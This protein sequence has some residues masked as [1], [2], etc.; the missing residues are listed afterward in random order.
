[1]T[2]VARQHIVAAAVAAAITSA[3]T[4]ADQ[5]F[6]IAPSPG[7][8]AQAI[9]SPV[10]NSLT[11][12]G[13]DYFLYFVPPADEAEQPF[14]GNGSA[15]VDAAYAS[16]DVAN[17]SSADAGLGYLR[18]SASSD[19]P[20]GAFFP[21]A[22]ANACWSETF[23]VTAPGLAG[24][25]GILQFTL[26]ASGA[27]AATGFA[28]STSVTVTGY[29]NGSQLMNNQWFSPGGS[30]PIGTDRQY[31][32][33]GVATYGIPPTD[34]KTVND[35][36]TFAVPFV[37]GTPFDLDICA[38]ALAGLRSV[39][40]VPGN[41]TAD[42]DFSAGITWGGIQAVLVNG[43]PIKGYSVAG[44]S[45]I[46]WSDPISGPAA[47]DLNGDGSVNA[48]DLALLL[49]AWGTPAGDLDGDG[50][51]GASDLAI[52]LAAWG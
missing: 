49:S 23:V 20:N 16:G 21:L 39:S 2:I 5:S 36:V 28:G 52:L 45:G 11:W 32:H 17:A 27:L 24:Q 25:P 14:A 15:G 10:S 3:S 35:T 7:G 50:T 19:V 18:L 34:G 6:L 51:T 43:S 13:A 44:A 33:W 42:A 22:A 37:F 38:N 1:M 12:P 8:F 30:D 29:V 46:D 26:D 41:S 40:G 9:A 31:G 48:Q 47:P 4:R